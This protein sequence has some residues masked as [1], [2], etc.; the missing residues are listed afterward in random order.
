MLNASPGRWRSVLPPLLSWLLPLA[1]SA[2]PSAVVTRSLRSPD[3]R[4]EVRID[5]GDRIRYGVLLRGRPL[6]ADSTLAMTIDGTVLGQ[7]PKLKSAKAASVD[8]EI[9]PPVRQKAARLRE[10]Y[11]ELRLELQG[12]YAV[13]FRAFNEGVAYRFETALKQAEV[14]VGGEE[15][16]FVFAGDDTV[17]YPKEESFFS[18]NE[19]AFVRLAVKEIAPS[20]LASIPAVVEAPEGVKIAIAESDVEDY[21]GLWLHGQSGKGLSATFPPYP[22]QEELTGDRNYRVVKGADYIALTK[23]RRS[24]PWRILGITEKDGELLTSP[25]VYLLARPSDLV[26]TSWIRPGKVSWDWWNANNVFGVPFK[27]GINTETYKYYIDFAARYGLEYVVLDEGWYPLGDLLHV[28]PA[29]DMDALTAYAR[30]K[31]V[32]IVLW[33]VAKTL[34]DQL[35]PALD[36]FERWGIRGIKVDFM[37]RDDQAMIG[38]YHKVCREAAKRKMLVDFH[39]AIRPALMTRTWPNL[40]ST[41]GVRGLEQ[42]KWGEDANPEHDVTI[43]FTRMFLG[44]MDYTPGAM[45]NAAKKSFAHIFEQPMS[46]GTRCHQLG[47]Y[48]VYESPLQMLADTPSAYLREPEMMEFLGP[49]PTVWDET[50]VLDARIA[51]YVL[52]ARRSGR[53]WY[54]GAL[55]DW[56]PR[57]LDLDLSFLPEGAFRM[58]SYE[59]GINADRYGSDYRKVATEVSR[60]RR[61]KIKLA[62]GGGFAARIQPHE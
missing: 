29:L 26:D 19:R 61:L 28:V 13:V 11:N 2:G 3:G 53:D 33:V 31:K 42:M 44:P 38:F 57:E 25:L 1:V 48:V 45:R 52:V 12:A 7:A 21:P 18:H 56:T 60:D 16:A 30:E 9:E 5:L 4:L 34:A 41:E 58:S 39:G 36:K 55:T 10:R 14:K 49:V 20:S 40:I 46:L 17:Y 15:A 22:L 50:R 47:M 32:G 8:R 6:L 43:P 35:E 62:P 59:D 54:V 24:Y 37:Q 23:G 27:S 51:D